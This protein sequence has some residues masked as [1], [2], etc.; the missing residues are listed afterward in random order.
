MSEQ[1][2]GR[3]VA[4]FAGSGSVADSHRSACKRSGRR[5]LSPTLKSRSTEMCCGQLTPMAWTSYSPLL[6]FTTRSTIHPV[7]AVKTASVALVAV[8]PLSM[9]PD[10]SV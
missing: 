5:L 3:R 7:Q 6:S 8:V 1:N 9:V 2:V 4:Q 10:P